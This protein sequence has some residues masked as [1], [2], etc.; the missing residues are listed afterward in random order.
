MSLGSIRN[1]F[2]V[3]NLEVLL[4]FLKYTLKDCLVSY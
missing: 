1:I 3:N 4:Y 2:K